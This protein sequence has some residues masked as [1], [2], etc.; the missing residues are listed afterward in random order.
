MN[1]G[2]SDAVTIGEY[3]EQG[4]LMQGYYYSPQ[5]NLANAPVAIKHNDN[6]IT[7]TSYYQN[8]HLNTPQMLTRPN[9]SVVW[10]GQYDAFGEVTQTNTQV[11]NPLR[12]L[13]QYQDD[14]TGLHYNWNRYYDNSIGRYVTSDPIGLNGGLNT[15]GY[16]LGNPLR[17]TDSRGLEVVAQDSISRNALNTL[18]SSSSTGESIVSSLNSSGANVNIRARSGVLDSVA[19][20]LGGGKSYYNPDTNTIIYDPNQG[21]DEFGMPNEIVLGHELVHAYHDE[22][23]GRNSR[24][25][26]KSTL[27]QWTVHGIPGGA[28]SEMQCF[29]NFSENAIR[30]DYGIKRR[31]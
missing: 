11:S 15:Y 5:N 19:S 2:Q 25:T 30:D 4:E 14:E 7:Q 3:N 22:V 16:A 29:P 9:G 18:Q 6:G 17:W 13:G 24:N 21:Q 10:Q 20:A 23:L 8:D 28:N 27:Q 26:L 12:F 1:I 31:R